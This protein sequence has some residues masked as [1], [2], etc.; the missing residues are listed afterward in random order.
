VSVPAVMPVTSMGAVFLGRLVDH[1]PLGGM[2]L[3]TCAALR[4]RFQSRL[5]SP[6]GFRIAV[7]RVAG[8]DTPVHGREVPGPLDTPRTATPASPGNRTSAR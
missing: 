5:G 1:R 7:L 8:N 6:G 3:Q 4:R 2:G